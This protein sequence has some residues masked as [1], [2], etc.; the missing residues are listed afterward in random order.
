MNPRR[1][2]RLASPTSVGRDWRGAVAR[3]RRAIEGPWKDR[4]WV[5][6]DHTNYYYD[7]ERFDQ[8]ETG[9]GGPAADLPD[10]IRYADYLIYTGL[11]SSLASLDGVELEPLPGGGEVSLALP[12]DPA[13]DPRP[14]L[15]LT[16]F[17]PDEL[18]G[19]GI[20]WSVREAL[21][22][23]KPPKILPA[24]NAGELCLS[25]SW[26]AEGRLRPAVTSRASA[27]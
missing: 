24:A 6:S 10:D 4:A 16:R 25:A 18:L 23:V 21:R 20:Q 17:E 26:R 27:H 19:M 8:P 3:L 5:H 11:W 1:L 15:E 9:G 7:P 13:A 14:Y 22:P 2:Q 12:L